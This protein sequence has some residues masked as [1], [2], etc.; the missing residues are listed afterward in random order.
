MNQS[1]INP[2]KLTKPIQLLAAW[3]VG[4]LSIS[5]SF[6]IAAANIETAWQSG[7]LV[8][9]AVVNV[10][11]FLSAVFCCKRSFVQSSKRILTIQV[12]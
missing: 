6:L 5:S 11:L 9:A 2:E 7:L 3:L 10:P 8:I 1:K 12:I 4:L